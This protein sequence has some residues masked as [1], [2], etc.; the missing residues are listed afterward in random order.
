MILEIGLIVAGVP[1]G[2]ALR[3][4]PLAINITNKALSYIIYVM[5]FLIGVS[6]GGN[7]DLLARIADLG[8]QGT[9]IGAGCALGSALVVWAVYRF[10]FRIHTS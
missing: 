5:L 2:Y 7:E 8:V 4:K 3:N 1:L 9:L 6:L 10:I